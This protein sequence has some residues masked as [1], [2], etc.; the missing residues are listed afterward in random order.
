MKT[1]IKYLLEVID[2]KREFIVDS[3]EYS[4]LSNACVEL[5]DLTECYKDEMRYNP[6]ERYKILIFKVI[7][8]KDKKT[9]KYINFDIDLI[10]YRYLY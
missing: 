4:D 10:D 1:K 6:L 9:K 7:M 3:R 5:E 8:K 2:S